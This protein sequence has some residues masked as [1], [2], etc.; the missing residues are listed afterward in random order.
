MPSP[1]VLW[2]NNFSNKN[3]A[4]CTSVELWTV[5][6]E[7]EVWILEAVLPATVNKKKEIQIEPSSGRNEQLSSAPNQ[8]S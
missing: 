3:N 8:C 6:D 2:P 1:S 7:R 4:K 5:A